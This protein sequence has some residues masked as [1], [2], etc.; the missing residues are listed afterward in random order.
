MLKLFCTELWDP[1]PP[2]QS[3]TPPPTPRPLEPPKVFS[4]NW[5]IVD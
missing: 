5:E 1:L 4:S 3:S 2:P